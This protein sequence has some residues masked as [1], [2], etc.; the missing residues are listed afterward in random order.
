[1]RK[2]DWEA[3]EA[4]LRELLAL[5]PNHA[6]AEAWPARCRPEA[7]GIRV[8]CITQARRLQAEGDLGGRAGSGG[9]RPASTRRIRDS[10]SCSPPYNAP[11]RRPSNRRQRAKWS[12]SPRLPP[13]GWDRR[14][15][16]KSRRRDSFHRLQPMQ[17]PR[18]RLPRRRFFAPCQA[19]LP[20]PARII[21]E[22]PRLSA[23]AGLPSRQGLYATA[24]LA[25]AALTLAVGIVV[26]HAFHR[27]PLKPAATFKVALRSS[28]EGA[29]I[30]V[31][32]KPCG[33][34][35]CEV[36]LPPGKHQANAALA[37]RQNAS[38]PFVVTN[39]GAREEVR[40]ILEAPPARISLSTNLAEG[41]LSVDGAVTAQIQGGEME[42][43]SLTPGQHTLEIESAAAKATLALDF[44]PDA[45]PKLTAPI[46]AQGVDAIVI[47]RYGSQAMLYCSAEGVP[48]LIDGKAEGASSTAGLGLQD[49][50]PGP[51]EVQMNINGLTTKLS[52][53]SSATSGIVASLLTERNVGPLLIVTGEDDV[54]VYVN[55][56]IGKRATK[57][58]HLLL[59]LAPK[60]YAVHIEKAGA[61]GGGPDGRRPAR[62]RSSPD[63]RSGSRQGHP[64]RSWPAGGNGGLAGRKTAWQRAGRRLFGVQHPTGEARGCP[65]EGRL[66]GHSRGVRVRAGQV[67]RGGRRATKRD[68]DS[69]DRG[70]S[71]RRRSPSESL[72]RGRN[73]GARPLGVRT[74]PAGGKLPGN[75]RRSA[76]PASY[77]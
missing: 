49:L 61:L 72:A 42:V 60:Q 18:S 56:Q 8:P 47:S 9:A 21:R 41:T 75:R 63:V 69:Q 43:P 20:L 46:Q 55:G 30:S 36:L 32:G 3:A 6:G 45:L 17:R 25:A 48:V 14:S 28:P 7:G 66:Q 76:V 23:P 53:E 34:S 16:S 37:G 40:L 31:D 19:R 51:H 27:P 29:A 59:Y 13:E 54:A 12:K 50:A 38:V 70:E 2:P 77:R 11:K 74:E 15:R 4:R 57:R 52:F 33:V 39:A 67:N 1:M 65:K 64:R 24:G 10:S 26:V 35:A 73:P 68:R 5:D 22:F 62:R 44:T 71:A 58:G